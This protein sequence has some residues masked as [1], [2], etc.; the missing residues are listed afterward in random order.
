MET[1]SRLEQLEQIIKNIKPSD[2]GF[3]RVKNFVLYSDNPY[4]EMPGTVLNNLEEFCVK[5]KVVQIT[6]LNVS[7][8]ETRII[9]VYEVSKIDL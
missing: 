3:L 9:A 1:E 6:F 7:Q 5:N 4:G 8:T 2:G